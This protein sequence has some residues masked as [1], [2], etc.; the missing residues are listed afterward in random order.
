MKKNCVIRLLA[1]EKALPPPLLF[2]QAVILIYPFLIV[3]NISSAFIS[4][5]SL[6]IA[7]H[8][9]MPMILYAFAYV[10]YQ[11]AALFQLVFLNTFFYGRKRKIIAQA[12]I[13]SAYSLGACFL[14]AGFAFLALDRFSIFDRQIY[15]PFFCLFTPSAIF[16]PYFI[17]SKA[18]RRIFIN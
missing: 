9:P 5:N 15:A 7:G 1:F 18:C 12:I 14:N 6:K 10:A 2:F 16:L 3:K 8:F 17:F 11:T 13:L 4:L